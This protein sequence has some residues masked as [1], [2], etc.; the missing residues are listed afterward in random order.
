L[1]GLQGALFT[2]YEATQL[3]EEASAS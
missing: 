2:I 3:D 1:R